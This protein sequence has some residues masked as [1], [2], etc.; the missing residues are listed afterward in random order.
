MTLLAALR[1]ALLDVRERLRTKLERQQ[2]PEPNTSR[3]VITDPPRLPVTQLF[4]VST[5]A[6]DAQHSRASQ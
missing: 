4:P 3:Y 1:D 6:I 5:P 2:E